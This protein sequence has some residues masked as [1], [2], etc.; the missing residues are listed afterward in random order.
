MPAEPGKGGRRP[1]RIGNYEVIAHIATGGMGAVYKALDT[2]TRRDVALK[3]LN[4]EMAAKPIIMER[5]RR[6]AR[7]AARLS[8]DNIV[9]IYEF[10]EDLGTYFLALEFVDGIDL[11]ELINRRR[12]LKPET[13]RQIAIQAGRALDHAHENGLVHRDVKPSNFLITRRDGVLVV[14]LTDLG[15]VRHVSE[16]EFRVTRDGTTVGTVD[17][18]SPEQ[19]RNAATAD[20]R[21]DIYSLGCTFYH[22]LAGHCPFPDGSLTERIYK[23]VEAPP[24]DVRHFNP[25]VPERMVAI[26]NRMLAK[27]PEDRYQTPHELL[28]DLED[29]ALRPAGEEADDGP[30]P[31]RPPPTIIKAPTPTSSPTNTAEAPTSPNPPL[32]PP[33]QGGVG[34]SKR[35]RFRDDDDFDPA[36]APVKPTEKRPASAAS[37]ER[38]R[39]EEEPSGR[40]RSKDPPVAH[41]PGSP[42]SAPPARKGL[43]RWWPFAAGALGLLVVGGIVVALLAGRALRGPP[44]TAARDVH[45]NRDSDKP[46]LPVPPEGPTD[47]TLTDKDGNGE[48]PK[49]KPDNGTKVEPKQPPDK[50][51]PAEL[52]RLRQEFEGPLARFPEP[53]AATATFRVSRAAPLTLP[54]PPGGGEGRVRGAGPNSF[55]SLAE[56]LARAPRAGHLVVEIHDNGP[57]FEPS[58]PPVVG[59][60]VTVRAGAGYRPLIAWEGSSGRF[61]TVEKGSLFLEGLDV[62]MR[63]ADEERPTTLFAVSGGDL[64]A[65]ACT[66]SVSG[67][68]PRGVRVFD[69]AAP[70]A[71][72]RCRLT[73]CFA[74]GADLTALNLE[75]SG[76]ILLD[77][78]L[79]LGSEQP[80]L[81]VTTAGKDDCTLRLVRSTLVGGKGLLHATSKDGSPA[82]KGLAWDA[83]LA[84][85]GAGAEGELLR[86]EGETGRM[87]WK[88][89]N[90]IYAGWGKLL[91]GTG[92]EIAATGLP[93]WRNLWG[94]AD[95]DQV[96]EAPWP[97]R[98]PASL[99]ECPARACD[100]ATVGGGSAGCDP[101]V[102]PVGRPSWPALTFDRLVM[103]PLTV[104]TEEEAPAIP[105]PGDGRYHGERFV[106]TRGMDLGQLL[107]ARLQNASPGPKVVLHLAGSGE[108]PTSPLLVRGAD[109]VIYFKPAENKAN[110]LI[111]VPNPSTCGDKPALIEVEGGG[112]ELI[113]ARIQFENSALAATP[114][115]MVRVQGGPL[116]LFNCR[117]EGPLRKTPA[118]YQE[119]IHFAGS[120]KEDQAGA[121]VC[122]LQQSV[123][124]SG[125]SV[126]R[127]QG[128]GARLLVQQCVLLAADDGL[129]FDPGVA[130]KARLNVHCQLN[131]VTAA[132]RGALLNVKDVPDLAPTAQPIIV[133]ADGNLLV[134]PFMEVPPRSA[135]LRYE[136]EA[137]ARGVLLWQGKGNGY[138]DKRLGAYAVAEGEREPAAQGH[139]VWAQLWGKSGEQQPVLLTWP[140]A[141]A[142]TF[143][144]DRLQ[145]ERLRPPAQARTAVGADLGAL[146]IGKK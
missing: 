129:V 52:A 83:L 76:D 66:F 67:R 65:R 15:L 64:A 124:L 32:A 108:Q 13:A 89:V 91:A 104:S 146:G 126:L 34:G 106:L 80:L 17:Y 8:H 33:C 20:I 117:L 30:L 145:L 26:L 71:S 37:R 133:Q 55:R 137:L 28:L 75:G 136:G 6:E 122:T 57:L 25:E 44:D 51:A 90:C 102:L 58:A 53:P 24:P 100:R 105:K 45:A 29:P 141:S 134:D 47:K 59:V 96:V 135:L 118:S 123:L 19:A 103:P 85:A 81:N 18:M 125:K 16:S 113:G 38:E 70:T 50:P 143:G 86:V 22:M 127:V 11:H 97:G 56:A 95:G 142:G 84:R 3:V 46:G 119:L 130:P 116:R 139:A 23:H 94:Y 138:D 41:A 61:V 40:S 120:G 9:R 39:P 92:K 77:D 48:K 43:P 115:R 101:A 79:I 107:R 69:L 131:R 78:C 128:I 87:G 49:G 63:T 42:Q 88:A 21:S 112:L 110:P 72:I 111:L 109:L 74:R 140:S 132:L 114:A 73:R 36:P 12:K 4:P 68:Q 1:L 144:I 27:K 82:L 31:S 62:V 2:Q 14:K 5:F 35:K 121:Q 10:G 54:S 60:S 98:L 7:A 93:H 99:E